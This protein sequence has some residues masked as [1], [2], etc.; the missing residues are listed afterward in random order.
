MGRGVYSGNITQDSWTEPDSRPRIVQYMGRHKNKNLPVIRSVILSIRYFVV[1]G[2]RVVSP[3][4][5]RH[6]LPSDGLFVMGWNELHGQLAKRMGRIHLE[7][8]QV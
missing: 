5:L 8:V 3:R 2:G 6:H 1:C 7:I 4:F